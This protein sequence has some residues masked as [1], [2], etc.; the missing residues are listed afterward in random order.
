MQRLVA[1]FSARSNTSNAFYDGFGG[2]GSV[3]IEMANYYNKV[4]YNEKN[5]EITSMYEV[6]RDNPEELIVLLQKAQKNNS[7]E[8]YLTVRAWDRHSSFSSLDK[9]TKAMRTIYLNKVC[10]NGLYRV[11]SSG[12]FNVPYGKYKSPLICDED[13]IRE[14]SILFNSKIIITNEDYW[15]VCHKATE[16]DVVYLDPPYDQETNVS[17]IGYNQNQFGRQEQNRLKE[18][19]DELTERN[20]F[21]VQSNSSTERIKKLYRD[22]ITSESYLTVHRSVGASEDSRRKIQELLFSNERLLRNEN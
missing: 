21:V 10:F 20:I 13:N 15:T 6:I 9:I 7:K 17:F 22:Y 3:S 1:L 4:I 8:Y 19:M 5:S 18:F 14:L 11:N 12:Q 2:G 16:N